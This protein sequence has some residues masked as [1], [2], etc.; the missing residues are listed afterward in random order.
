MS[1]E[2]FRFQSNTN[3]VQKRPT[4]RLGVMQATAVVN[5]VR[6]S[7]L[8][9]TVVV[10]CIDDAGVEQEAGQLLF[11]VRNARFVNLALD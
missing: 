8:L 10:H 11:A 3:Y 6:R 9:F 2:R 7:N 4:V 5:V 1:L